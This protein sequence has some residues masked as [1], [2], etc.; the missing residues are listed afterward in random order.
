M[1]I[2]TCLSTNP[3]KFTAVPF[4]G[5]FEENVKSIAN[6]GFDGVELAI[7]DPSLIDAEYILKIISDAK[8]EVPA[9]GTGQ[10]WGEERLSFTAVDETVRHKAIER[11]VSHIPFASKADAIIIIGL[12]RGVPDNSISIDAINTWLREAFG[13][14]CKRAE[15]YGVRIAF[16]PINRYETSLLNCVKDGLNFIDSLGFSNLGMLLDAFHMNIEEPSIEQSILSAGDR[17]FHF[18][19]A[20]SNRWYPGAGHLNFSSIL[21][22]LYSTGYT[23][24]ISGEHL[25]NPE[26][27]FSAREGLK[28][29]RNF[30][31][32]IVFK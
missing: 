13:I 9:I 24:F 25:P 11:I 19:Y 14:C 16:E 20:D 31:K 3:A 8:L 6:L 2:S 15:E 22:A 1:K 28:Y 12:I 21:N 29:M 32:K 18:H 17:I 4:K 5:N 10:A 7:R 30:E 27:I 26:P 23:G